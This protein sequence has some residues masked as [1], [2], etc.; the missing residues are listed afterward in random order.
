MPCEKRERERER[1]RKKGKKKRK[2][3]K[4]EDEREKGDR[5]FFHYLF[6]TRL[7]NAY[8]TEVLLFISNVTPS[9][10]IIIII[11]KK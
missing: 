10:I 5:R 9:K 3:K 8:L 6:F 7:I 2:E 4:R 1:G 11:I